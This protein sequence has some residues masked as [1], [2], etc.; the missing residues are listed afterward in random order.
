M[1]RFIQDPR[2]GKLVPAEQYR[3]PA[4]VAH[5]VLP[6]IDPFVSPVDGSVVSSRSHLR[7]HQERHDVRQHGE[8]GENNGQAYFARKAQERM[9]RAQGSLPEQ[10]RERVRAITRAIEKHE[11]S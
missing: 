9:R 4:L 8:Y 7:A 5:T 10:R 6:D 11:R 3:R 1:A 2:T